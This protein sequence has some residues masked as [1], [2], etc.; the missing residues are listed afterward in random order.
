MKDKIRV[1]F[2]KMKESAAGL[3]GK[4]KGAFRKKEKAPQE[5]EASQPED[6]WQDDMYPEDLPQA[7]EEETRPSPEDGGEEGSP[8]KKKGLKMGTG[9]LKVAKGIWTIPW[10]IFKVALGVAGTVL[11]ICLVT[12]IVFACSLANYLQNDVMPYS[13]LDANVQ[14]SIDQSSFIYSTDRDTGEIKLL[15]QIY[16]ETDRQWASYDE[17]P[18]GLEK[19]AIAIEDK[20]FHE[21]AGVDWFRTGKACIQIFMGQTDFG[22]STITQQFIKNFT[23]YDDVTVRR[24][25]TEIFQAL[26]YEKNHTKE[27]IMENYLNMIYLGEGCYGVKSAA[28]VYFGKELQDL[29][30]AECASLIS[31]TNNPSLYDP[32]ISQKNNRERQLLVLSQMLDQELITPAEYQEAVNQEM[33]FKNTSG[34][35]EIFT[36][37]NCG[38]EGTET[39]YDYD[40]TDKIDKC[41]ACG[42]EFYLR[43]E[44][45]DSRGYSYFVDAVINNVVY[46][47]MDK[48]GAEHTYQNYQL[49]LK[50]LKTGGYHIYATIDTE[51]QAMVDEIYENK[52][53]LPEDHSQQQ[54]QSAAVVVDN[55]TGDIVALAGGV[56]KK[57]GYLEQN[58]ATQST[59]Q[60]G[61]SIKPVSVYA[62]AIDLG[63]ITPATIMKDGPVYDRYPMN[64]YRT[65]SGYTNVLT[66]IQNSLN[67]VAAHT[68]ELMGYEQGYYYAKEQ[69]GLSTLVEN[70][71]ALAP[72]SMGALTYGARVSDMAS[73]FAVFAND[74][75]W[76]EGRL[77]TKVYDSQGNVVLDNTQDS[78]QAIS[79]KTSIYMNYMLQYIVDTTY[80]GGVAKVPGITC[81]GKTG[82]TTDDKDRWFCGYNHYYTTAVWV[83]YDEPEQIVLDSRD[84]NPAAIMW[85][86]VMT[87][88]S[89]GKP[90]VALYSSSGMR[91]I[92]MCRDSGQYAT[93]LCQEDVRGSRVLS[94]LVFPEDYP[95][96]KNCEKHVKVEYCEGGKAIANEYCKQIKGNT[97]SEKSMVKYTEEDLEYWEE[98]CSIKIPEEVIYS[99]DNV[100]KLHTK[101]MLEEQNK[102]TEPPTEP[103]EPTDPSAVG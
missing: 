94:A 17:I 59:L 19:A 20:R 6:L 32:Y 39:Q 47:L 93:E 5:P 36:C 97:V 23:E 34:S 79:Q 92:S 99:E 21:H 16:A 72:L 18:S 67:A 37:P 71:K 83:G 51:A 38:F 98:S 35:Q 75:V 2:H 44:E 69:F 74:G 43:P 90:D 57:T 52:N 25:I 95:N 65:Y 62:P 101:E 26:E 10:T 73:A 76:R 22:G 31:I 66:G 58:R 103:T 102:P 46:D 8:A 24:K 82:T 63:L 3:S 64:Y 41:P 81:A 29:T 30:I 77:Y 13:S 40:T 7:P 86:K 80:S 48:D 45:E 33:V 84:T 68:V 56:G 87:K 70:D 9:W 61:S 12:G 49:Y 1:F 14:A 96:E 42:H 11:V 28:R 100:C 60:T 85:N 89:S 4:I 55:E 27:E 91:T 54:L 50:N 15:Q 78:H 88:L 53:N